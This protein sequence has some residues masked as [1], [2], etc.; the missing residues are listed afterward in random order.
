MHC[1]QAPNAMCDARD[2]GFAEMQ[3]PIF[4]AVQLLSSPHTAA[5]AAAAA[6]KQLLWAWLELAA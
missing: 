1:L 6:S 4:P 2:I 5:A 3:S